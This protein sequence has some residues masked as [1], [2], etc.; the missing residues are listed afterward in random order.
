VRKRNGLKTRTVVV[1]CAAPL[2]LPTVVTRRWKQR[3]CLPS[4]RLSP[5]PSGRRRRPP[6]SESDSERC[7]ASPHPSR[8]PSRPPAEYSVQASITHQPEATRPAHRPTPAREHPRSRCAAH[9]TGR[10]PPPLLPTPAHPPS[11]VGVA[12]T[13]EVCH[14]V[15]VCTGSRGGLTAARRGP[16]TRPACPGLG[17]R[18]PPS[19]HRHGTAQ[20][21][22]AAPGAPQEDA[23]ARMQERA[24]RAAPA[25][26]RMSRAQWRAA[27][28]PR[29]PPPSR[30]R[31]PPASR[32]PAPSLPPHWRA[33]RPAPSGETPSSLL[34][35]QASPPSPLLLRG[36]PPP[37]TGEPPSLSKSRL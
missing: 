31:A 36:P 33:T 19:S 6:S 9:G 20:S 21:R 8:D 34:S 24:V 32:A 28:F 1:G 14:G 15:R 18:G 2:G 27:A 3:S 11:L 4:G 29:A 26:T 23:H 10:R 17:C 16:A 35:P 5:P 30:A 37:A 22:C 25:K 7:R 13:A 12:R